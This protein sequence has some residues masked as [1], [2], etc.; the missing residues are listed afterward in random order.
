MLLLP[1]L[2]TLAQQEQV[3]IASWQFGE[4]LQA[5]V[6]LL[7]TNA[8]PKVQHKAGMVSAAVKAVADMMKEDKKLTI[9]KTLQ[10]KPC[11]CNLLACLHVSL[12]CLTCCCAWRF[13]LHNKTYARVH[14]K[15]CTFT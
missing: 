9:L 1:A 8:P 3:T 11:W 12:S 10:V 5:H 7:Q 6:C 13:G 4:G 14:L 15:D 2:P